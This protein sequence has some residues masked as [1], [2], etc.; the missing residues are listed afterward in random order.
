MLPPDREWPPHPRAAVA[1]S[2]VIEISGRVAHDAELRVQPDG[3]RG[4]LV[5][6]LDTGS[7]YPYAVTLPVTGDHHSLQDAQALARSLRRGTF[8]RVRAHGCLPRTDHGNAV[9]QLLNVE[10]VAATS[11]EG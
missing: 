6:E 9:L 3:A 4:V 5:L 8:A 7:G 11:E 1:A 10:T 2:G